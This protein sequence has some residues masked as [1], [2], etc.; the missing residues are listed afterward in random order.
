MGW[1]RLQGMLTIGCLFWVSCTPTAPYRTALPLPPPECPVSISGVVPTACQTSQHEHT[2][3]YD[4]LF[5]E[6]DDQGLLYPDPSQDTPT[7]W[8]SQINEIIS[9]LHALV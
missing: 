9:R 4:L 3:E 7:Q 6:F 5:V 8:P 1:I 2:N